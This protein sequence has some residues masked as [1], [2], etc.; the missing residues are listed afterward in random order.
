MREKEQAGDL[1]KR[2]DERRNGWGK[3]GWKAEIARKCWREGS[4]RQTQN[5][6]D[7]GARVWDGSASNE[8]AGAPDCT[9]GS[10]RLH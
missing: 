6:K 3:R 10:T 1:G 8:L 9:S 5:E 2:E 4:E 7:R